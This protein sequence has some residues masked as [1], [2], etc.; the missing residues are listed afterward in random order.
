MSESNDDVEVEAEY[1]PVL[2]EEGREISRPQWV[3]SQRVRVEQ[4][5]LLLEEGSCE[6]EDE[7]ERSGRGAAKDDDIDDEDS[8]EEEEEEQKEE[9]RTH[10]GEWH[11]N[12]ALSLGLEP[13]GERGVVRCARCKFCDRFGKVP[14]GGLRKRSPPKKS[15]TFTN[16]RKDNVLRHHEGLHARR[17]SEYAEIYRQYESERRPTQKK[18]LHAQLVGY[19]KPPETVLSFV[20]KPKKEDMYIEIKLLE[21]ARSLYGEPDYE[22][23]NEEGNHSD[24]ENEIG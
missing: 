8:D 5:I 23:E 10:N 20:Q 1:I 16:F 2:D 7:E 11:D 22:L 14:T 12:Y 21:M 4:R 3:S 9:D 17:W 24:L 13:V 18:K 19:F 15:K 6:R